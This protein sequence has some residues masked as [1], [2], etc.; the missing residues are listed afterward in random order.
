M[1]R[2]RTTGYCFGAPPA[3]YLAYKNESP[4]AILAHPSQL[5]SPPE[6]LGGRN[7]TLGYER[8]W[9]KCTHG[10]GI[11]AVSDSAIEGAS[12]RR[13][14]ELLSTAVDLSI[15]TTRYALAL[16]DLVFKYTSVE[17]DSQVS[18]DGAGPSSPRFEI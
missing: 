8:T 12:P 11:L 9:G 10:F 1:T 15:D 4:V 13:L 6:S 16:N 7:V 14:S 3:L 17:P 2:F 5:E 18:N